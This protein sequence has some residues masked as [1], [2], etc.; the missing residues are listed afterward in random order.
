[1][2]R[3]FKVLVTAALAVTGSAGAMVVGAS[4]ASAQD[5]G[6]DTCL[7]GYVWREATSGDHVCVTPGTRSQAAYDNSQATARRAALRIWIT[8]WSPS[9]SCGTGCT[10]NQGGTPYIKINGD[11]FNI[12]SRVWLGYYQQKNGRL[13]KG[14]WVTATP[15]SPLAGGSFGLQ[16]DRL[17]CGKGATTA[18]IRA[19]DERSAR[20]SSP[21][22]VRIGTCATL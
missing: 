7:Q 12:G 1:M 17:D 18:Y 11:H 14:N 4:S 21:L 10:T 9:G 3:L 6:P 13:I 20:W 2:N 5:Y 19:F 16:T 15:H 22:Y 8:H